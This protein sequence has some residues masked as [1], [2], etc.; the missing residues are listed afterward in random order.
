MNNLQHGTGISK[1]VLGR[2]SRLWMIHYVSET[3]FLGKNQNQ[4][5][6]SYMEINVKERGKVH[7]KEDKR[8]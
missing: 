2:N 3:D 8:L 7:K 1:H 4:W 5:K 6:A